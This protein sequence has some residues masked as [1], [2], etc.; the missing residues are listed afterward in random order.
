MLPD[1]DPPPRRLLSLLPAPD[2]TGVLPAV[3][4]RPAAVRPGV[5]PAGNGTAKAVELTSF[6]SAEGGAEETS[7]SALK[8]FL[9]LGATADAAPPL[10]PPRISSLGT[11][12]RRYTECPK[13]TFYI[14]FREQESFVNVTYNFDFF[15]PNLSSYL[16]TKSRQASIKLYGTYLFSI[17]SMKFCKLKHSAQ[18]GIDFLP[19]L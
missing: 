2:R 15:A 7:S 14:H 11:K 12:A 18:V 8:F 13:I 6:A 5:P 1:P 19:G 17:C 4:G 16:N 10:S 9:D 3:K